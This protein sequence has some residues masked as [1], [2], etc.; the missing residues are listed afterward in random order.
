MKKILAMCALFFSFTANASMQAIG[1]ALPNNTLEVF[2]FNNNL[3]EA[4]CVQTEGVRPAAYKYVFYVA[5][6]HETV[7]FGF[8]KQDDGSTAFAVACKK[9]EHTSW[10]DCTPSSSQIPAGDYVSYKPAYDG[11][12][13]FMLVGHDKNKNTMIAACRDGSGIWTNCSP[14]T[15]DAAYFHPG[16]VTYGDKQW[17]IFSSHFPEWDGNYNIARAL[18]MDTVRAWKNCDAKINMHDEFSM[19]GIEAVTYLLKENQWIAV[20]M[21][22]DDTDI[23]RSICR[24]QNESVWKNCTGGTFPSNGMLNLVQNSQGALIQLN[25]VS[26][27]SAIT[28]QALCRASSGVWKNCTGKLEQNNQLYMDALENADGKWVVAG[29]EIDPVNGTITQYITATQT[30]NNWTTVTQAADQQ[31]SIVDL[32]H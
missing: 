15:Q 10:Q 21:D 4:G 12:G 8:H 20:G 11:I 6:S 2:C 25:M 27:G 16:A 9:N 30:Q 7:A 13:S 1:N 31:A 23:F 14:T 19:F 29:N 5:A 26:K 3:W 32:F 17:M 22:Y 18:C 24:K 28:T